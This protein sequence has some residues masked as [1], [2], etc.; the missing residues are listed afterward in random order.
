VSVASNVHGKF[1]LANGILAIP[2]V[3]FEV[4][5]A[6]VELAGSSDLKGRTLGLAGTLQM[7]ATVSQAVGGFKSIFLKVADPFFKKNGM[8]ASCRSR[9]KARSTHRRSG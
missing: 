3:A 4:P 2:T 9:S 5:G 1:A 7:K 6:K 8:G